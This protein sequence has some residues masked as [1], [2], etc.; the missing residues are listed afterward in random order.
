MNAIQTFTD[1]INADGGMGEYGLRVLPHDDAADVGD[2]LA[3]SFVWIDGEQTDEQLN[4]T[5]SVGCD[6]DTVARAL[7]IIERNGY[8]GSRIA[9]IVGDRAESGEDEG[10]R[11]IRDAQVLAIISR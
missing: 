6:A 7:A 2:T 10:E 9:L 4:G 1:A 8:S 11:V 5:S 3:P